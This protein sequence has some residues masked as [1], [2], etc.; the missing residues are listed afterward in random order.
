[1]RR[2]L[3]ILGLMIASNVVLGGGIVTNTNQSTA[4]TR[5]LVR[6][7][8]TDVDAAFFNP[9]GLTKLPDGLHLSLSNQTISQTM[10][11]KNTSLKKTFEGDVFAPVFPDFY[12]VYKKNKLAFSLGFMPIGGGGSA[13][14]ANGVPMIE[15]P[16]ADI[17]NQLNNP[18][19]GVDI[20]GYSMNAS[21][22]GSSVYFGLQAGISYAINDMLSIYGG[23]RYVWVKNTYNGEMKD[24]M[25][26]TAAG[27]V[28]ANTLMNN[29][30]AQ[31]SAGATAAQM[32][33]QS[34]QPLIDNN[35]GGLT[36]AQA[37]SAG[38]LTAQQRQQLEM[39]L[40]KL[41]RTN[42]EISKMTLKQAQDLYSFASNH[43][44]EKATE[45]KAGAQLFGGQTL[46]TEQTGS[47]IT[48]IVGVNLSLLEDR[49]NIGIKYEFHTNIELT[50]KTAKGKG[51][52]T[53]FTPDGKPVEMFADGKKTGADIPALL[54]IGAQYKITDKFTTQV[55]YH[56]YMDKNLGW[57]NEMQNKTTVNIIDKNLW[58]I[59]VGF[60][61]QLTD[62]LLLSTGYLRGQTGVADNYHN[63]M[64]FSLRSNTYGLGGAYKINDIF[65][66]QA[67]VFYVQYNDKTVGQQ[68]YGKSNLGFSIGVD[69]TFGDL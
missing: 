4:W 67:G 18:Q 53:G 13:S 65:R 38:A 11:I 57:A 29:L 56:L 2:V 52:T 9:A 40:Q 17:A 47:G 21:F 54:S 27:N 5:M 20:Q 44:K 31:L 3:L 10:S 68:T 19:A 30:S 8:S 69:F 61:Y 7:A 46:E 39:G 42:E 28:P 23:A 33:S 51:F 63:D 49:L 12:A 6:D 59:G 34:M 24:I 64:R 37:Q 50:N 22:D 25:F 58:E 32:A 66:L 15:L 36:F 62:K 16:V 48:P 35:V 1:M 41:G 43:L 14:Y 26:K 55:G 45:L 60:E